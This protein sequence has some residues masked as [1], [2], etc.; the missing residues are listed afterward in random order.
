MK[1]L[2]TGCAGFIGHAFTEKLLKKNVNVVG[3]D[4]MTRYYSTELKN[5]RLQNL[6]TNKNFVYYNT[7]ISSLETNQIV[8]KGKFDAVIHLAAQPG[9]RISRSNFEKYIKSNII[10]FA[11]FSI[12][13]QKAAIPFFLYASSSSV[14]GNSAALPFSEFETNLRP[15]SFYGTTKLLNEIYSRNFFDPNV[16][17]HIG[18]RFFTVYGPLGRPDM[19]Y[20]R[21][22]HSAINNK[23]FILYGNGE[24]LRDFTFI[25][26]A[27]ESMYR[28]LKKLI[29]SSNPYPPLLNIGGGNPITMNKVI[30]TVE[31]L[32]KRKILFEKRESLSQD[33]L[34]TKADFKLL[35]DYSSYVPKTTF[36][37]GIKKTYRW[38][39]KNNLTNKL[40]TWIDSSK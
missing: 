36:E 19:S 34:S 32:T 18:L 6:L 35:S 5:F 17:K 23:K 31:I 15:T 2:V 4:N 30:E 14:Y 12:F 7:S 22:L 27:V 3:I 16:T 24:H 1:I 11:K 40:E 13:I 8:H 37:Y 28:V 26:D 38:I 29:N 10:D 33:M 9:V 21:L 25:T 39:V 20:F